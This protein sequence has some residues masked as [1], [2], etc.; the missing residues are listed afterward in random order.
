MWRLWLVS[1]KNS[2]L[3]KVCDKKVIFL[4]LIITLF[5]FNIVIFLSNYLDRLQWEPLLASTGLSGL[6]V[7]SLLAI[8]SGP[9]RVTLQLHSLFLMALSCHIALR[10]MFPIVV[11]WSMYTYQ[12]NDSLVFLCKPR[13]PRPAS[14]NSRIAVCSLVTEPS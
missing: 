11:P 14:S 8:V 7:I 9:S 2:S 3:D 5:L 13:L 10:C 1:L 6:Q 4:C 12:S